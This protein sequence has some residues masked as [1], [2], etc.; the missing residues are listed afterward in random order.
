MAREETPG[1]NFVIIF[2][3]TAQKLTN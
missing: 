3:P 2:D 1:I